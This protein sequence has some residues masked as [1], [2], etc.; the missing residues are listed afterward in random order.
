MCNIIP[1]T[2]Y[3]LPFKSYL[4]I[5]I[6]ELLKNLKPH[7]FRHHTD[8][9]EVVVWLGRDEENI[10]Q[11][12]FGLVRSTNAFLDE[13]LDRFGSVFDIPTIASRARSAT[14]DRDGTNFGKW[15]PSVG[16]LGFGL[17]KRLASQSGVSFDGGTARSTLLR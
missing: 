17:F 7:I 14:T 9:R 8:A 10:A 5:A 4:A 11:D 15:C 12:C 3:P 6:S 16:L 13:Q 2:T 1:P